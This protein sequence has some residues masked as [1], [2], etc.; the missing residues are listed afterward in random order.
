MRARERSPHSVLSNG[1]ADSSANSSSIHEHL[2]RATADQ[3]RRL[4]HGLRYVLSD[5]LSPDRYVKLL[6]AFFG[7]Y[8]PLEDF[9]AH[10]E[11][12]SPQLGLPIIRRSALLRR[13]LRAFGG[14]PE[15]MAMC[16]AVPTFSRSG[17]IAG[18]IYVVEGACLGGQVIARAVMQQLGVGRGD[19]AAF[20]TGD[21][22]LTA[23]R[24][25]RV[26]AWLEARDRSP[27]ERGEMV[28]GACR[29]FGAFSQWLLARE[30][31]DE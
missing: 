20:F 26:L 23:A 8:V 12:T 24:W 5:R 9:F 6:A 28:D 4:D 3:H 10:W 16:A 30:V 25:K 27:G 31:L 22:A 14:T 17:E 18:A 1:T 29:T 19:G 11:A 21:G 2:R 13:D 7:F 15:H